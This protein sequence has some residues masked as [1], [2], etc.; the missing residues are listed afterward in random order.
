MMMMIMMMI[1]IIIIIITTV[2]RSVQ[3]KHTVWAKVKFV[4]AKLAV[5][6]LGYKGCV[7]VCKEQGPLVAQA[8]S[9]RSL[10]AEV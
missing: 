10:V 9:R 7:S 4:N 2:L 3:N 8:G 5:H 6:I 1:I